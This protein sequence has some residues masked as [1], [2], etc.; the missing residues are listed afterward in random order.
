[1]AAVLLFIIGGIFYHKNYY[2]KTIH[3]EN[4]C[5]V[6]SS[7]YFE[8]ICNGFR[9]SRYVCFKPFWLVSYG[10]I[11][12][13]IDARIEHGGF[14]SV[15]DA[16]NELIRYRVGT[17]YPCWCNVIEPFKATWDEPNTFNGMMLLIFGAVATLLSLVGTFFGCRAHKNMKVAEKRFYPL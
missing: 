3:E 5:E 10:V 6:M 8:S 1:V 13:R 16:E 14:R 4:S 9:G 2:A 11:E 17:S 7:S 12:E 15:A